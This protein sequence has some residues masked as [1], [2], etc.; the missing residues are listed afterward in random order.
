MLTRRADAVAWL[1]A[2]IGKPKGFERIA[3]WIAP[4]ESLRA[5][6]EVCLVRDE[7]LFLTRPNN[8]IG[9]HAAL[10]GSYEPELRSLMRASLVPG[11][12]AID[13]GANAGWHTLLMAKCVGPKGLVLA[14]EANP[15]VCR[16][17]ERNVAINRFAQVRILCHALGEAEGEL[18]FLDI[19]DEDPG[20]GSGHVVRG[21]EAVAANRVA[22][23]PLDALVREAGIARLDLIK[24][25][26]EG[27]EWPVLQGA[28]STIAKFRPPIIFEF[29]AN[30]APRGGGTP[31]LLWDFFA[32]QG[33]ELSIPGR[34]GAPSRIEQ[35]RWPA[36]AN[37]LAQPRETPT[38]L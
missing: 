3:R 20:S 17:L 13:A 11:G 25:D 38:R 22:V 6:G 8:V 26:V 23:R 37:I 5:L 33:Y 18:S 1:G 19:A 21:D 7:M 27:F 30:Y 35:T 10:F 31:E 9:W 2:R 14:A 32:G 36:C 24:I 15:P 4:P 12:V 29:D 16:H 28:R 34:K